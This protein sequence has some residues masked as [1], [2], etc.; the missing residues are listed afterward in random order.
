MHFHCHVSPKGQ[1][2][3]CLIISSNVHVLR[4][5]LFI[6]LRFDMNCE[7]SRTFCEVDAKEGD[8]VDFIKTLP[9][10]IN[11]SQFM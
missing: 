4:G 2:L 7:D 10:T 6:T 5:W 1:A 3:L 9:D 11:V 8:T